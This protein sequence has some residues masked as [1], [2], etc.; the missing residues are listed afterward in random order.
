V[1]FLVGVIAVIA[2][3]LVLLTWIFILF[4]LFMRRDLKGWHKALWLLGI[5]LFPIL[6]AIVYVIVRP[7]NTAWAGDR[8]EP[9]RNSRE[10]QVRELQKLA[11]LRDQ[12]TITPDQFEVMKDRVIH[13]TPAEAEAA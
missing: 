2:F 7:K 11:W 3:I 8:A 5:I 13:G 4:D 10:W 9:D 6:G 12:G 1:E